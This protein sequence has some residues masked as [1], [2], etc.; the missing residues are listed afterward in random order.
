[1]LDYKNRFILEYFSLND[2]IRKLTKIVEAYNDGTLAFTL[3]CPVELLQ[4]QL[5]AMTEYKSIL[6]ERAKIEDIKL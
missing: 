1:M 2:R 5:N 4:R 3:S 6:D